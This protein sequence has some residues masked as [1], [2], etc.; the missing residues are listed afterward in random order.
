MDPLLEIL[1]NDARTSLEDLA[2]MTASTPEAVA[3]KIDGYEKSGVIRGY[4]AILNEDALSLPQVNAVI[5]VKIR[6][7]R[8]GGFDP[9][10]TRIARF[11]E[12]ESV[13]LMSGGTYDL[14]LFIHGESLQQVAS[15]VARR[16]S[17]LDGVLATATH[18]M[19]KTYKLFG[20]LMEPA[21]ADDRLQVSP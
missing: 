14:V 10:A 12:V 20:V 6:P 11:A 13:Y 3:A 1:K 17:T 21:P 16:L 7:E 4:Q 8:E 18:F 9:V 2:K 5:E 19:L 15:F